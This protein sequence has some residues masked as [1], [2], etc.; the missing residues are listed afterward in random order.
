MK[1]ERA[2]DMMR[3]HDVRIADI[4]TSLGFSNIYYF[5]KVF[6]KVTGVPPTEYIKSMKI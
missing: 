6:R 5:S 1:V 3:G 4:A 2:K